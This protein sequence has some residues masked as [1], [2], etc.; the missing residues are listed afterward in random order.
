MSMLK[1]GGVPVDAIAKSCG[2]PVYIYDEDKIEKQLSEYKAY[3]TS[4][5]FKTDIVYASK[6]FTCSTMI[7]KIAEA[8]AG[9]DVVSGGELLVAARGGMPMERVYFHGNN[10]TG[11]EIELALDLG[12]GTI[13]LDN[14]TECKTL[15]KITKRKRKRINAM[16]RINP[17][18]EAHTHEYI[19]TGGSNSKFG[20]NIDKKADIAKLVTAAGESEYIDFKGFHSHIGSQIFE[21]TAF[22]RAAEVLIHFYKDMKQEYGIECKWLSLGGGFGIRY[23]DSDKPLSIAMMCESLIGK[24]EELIAEKGVVIEKITI[25]PGRSVVG[26]AG[27]TL[28]TV[29]YQKTAEDRNYVFVDGGMG[30]NIR[31]ALY[32]ADYSCDI[33]NR[34]GEEKVKEWYVAGKYCESGDILIK[35]TLLPETIEQGDL[36]IIYSTGAYGYSM[37]SN[38]NGIGKLPV[39]FAKNGKARMVIRRET[40]EDILKLETDEEVKI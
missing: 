22:K 13:V 12:C 35:K 1:I 10:K 11:E 4:S 23:T 30:D 27:S 37:A 26:E 25:E 16:L 9:I 39:V 2:T 19:M 40:T 14:I 38:Y 36:L 29:G 20:I 31:P 6:A 3:F 28:Y 32:Q 34:M 21:D 5:L 15:V 17:G 18:V 7:Q 24:C 8:E 33:A